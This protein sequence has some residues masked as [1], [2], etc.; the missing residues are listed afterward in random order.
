[1]YYVYVIESQI[2]KT[3]Y[4]G[5]TENEPPKRLKAHNDGKVPSSRNK[6][7]W[8]I[9]YLEGYLHKKDALAREK[10]LKSGS[11]YRF[12]KKQLKYYLSE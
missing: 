9:I 5:F 11:G 7:P 4:I 6:R 1:M 3:H 2:D 8:K 10:F 12:I